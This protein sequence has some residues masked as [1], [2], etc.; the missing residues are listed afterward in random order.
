MRWVLAG[1][2][3][4]LWFILA[5]GGT[6]WAQ[7]AEGWQK[8]AAAR[9][10]HITVTAQDKLATMRREI[11][12]CYPIAPSSREL[13][14]YY[15]QALEVV[16]GQIQSFSLGGPLPVR[17]ESVQEYRQERNWPDNPLDGWRPLP[18][19]KPGDKPVPGGLVWQIC[20]PE[21]YTASPGRHWASPAS[22]ELS[23]YG[24]RLQTSPDAHPQQGNAQWAKVLPGTLAMAGEYKPPFSETEGADTDKFW[25]LSFAQYEAALRD[26]AVEWYEH[27]L[28]L[29]KDRKNVTSDL[30]IAN[31]QSAL[32]GERGLYPLREK[33]M[34]TP[35]RQWDAKYVEGYLQESLSEVFDS[36]LAY[37]S[38]YDETIS[39]QERLM[40]LGFIKEMPANPC[41]NW[42]PMRI[43]DASEGFHPGELFIEVCPTR[44]Y[45]D[46]QEG[47]APGSCV[48]GVYGE[49]PKLWVR[50]LSGRFTDYEFSEWARVPAGAVD[51]T[52]LGGESLLATDYRYEMPSLD[53]PTDRV[54]G[55]HRLSADAWL[56]SEFSRDEAADV[57]K[58]KDRAAWT[59]A[60]MDKYLGYALWSLYSP[61]EIY[62]DV[63]GYMPAVRQLY[64][65]AGYLK[66]WPLNPYDG[67]RPVRILKPEDAF[68][69]GDIVWQSDPANPKAY[70]LSIY[71]WDQAAPVPERCKLLKGHEAW[72]K[73]LPGTRYTVG[74]YAA[75]LSEE[76]KREE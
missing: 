28:V 27:R 17:L 8:Y 30:V 21:R 46:T 45:D 74:A 48:L 54:A 59:P 41:N 38:A 12:R 50:R 64:V 43:L 15:R 37:A 13:D 7:P 20:P 18:I 58:A 60:E 69:P 49:T 53:V 11:E 16:H 51:V 5:A 6:A 44:Y 29:P 42:L 55:R 52:C 47:V 10:V 62:K 1:G 72:A 66:T 9:D 65:G 68:S 63:M 26:E 36:M 75:T 25:L 14:E 34:A 19:L 67:W 33:L 61:A 32:L 76:K 23:I 3:A 40:E 2:V 56:S 24:S 4:M 71:G 70:E 57:L 31:L 35:R 39:N 22:Y 73:V